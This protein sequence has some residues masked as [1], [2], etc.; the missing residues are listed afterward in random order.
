VAPSG[1]TTSSAIGK[2]SDAV[3]NSLKAGTSPAFRLRCRA[4]VGYFQTGCTFN[5]TVDA[6][7]ACTAQSYDYP[8]TSYGTGQFIQGCITGLADGDNDTN[9]RLIYGAN[10]C[11]GLGC[12]TTEGWGGTGELWVR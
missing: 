4:K 3:I 2:F 11:G 1:L 12:D 9:D 7:G 5:A 6:S 10:H 8:P